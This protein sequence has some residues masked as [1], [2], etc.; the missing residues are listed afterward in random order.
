MKKLLLLVFALL[1]TTSIYSQNDGPLIPKP[2]GSKEI[3]EKK[4]KKPFT[5]FKDVYKDFFVERPD[6]DSLYDIPRVIEVQNILILTID[7]E[8]VLEN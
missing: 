4:D 2:L 5:F 7:M 6:G 1:L 3:K 8:L